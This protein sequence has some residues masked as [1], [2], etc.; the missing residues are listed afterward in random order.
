MG[1][2]EGFFVKEEGVSE[3]NNSKVSSVLEI[4]SGDV[5]VLICRDKAFL[6]VRP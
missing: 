2:G 1:T 6:F 5:R 4:H 3:M